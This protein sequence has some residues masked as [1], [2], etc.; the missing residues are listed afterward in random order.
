MEVKHI[1]LTDI[2][3]DEAFNCRG[4]ISPMDVVDLSKD[5]EER[6]LIQPV[7]VRPY[8][9]EEET[10]IG[11]KYLLIV[12]YRRYTAHKILGRETI[13]CVIRTNIGD[14]TSTRLFNLSE[15]LHRK[16]LN[17]LQEAKALEKLMEL[18]LGEY[19]TAERLKKSRGWVQIRYMVLKLPVEVQEEIAAGFFTQPQIRDLYTHFKR[20]GKEACFDIAREFKDDK[21]KGRK[22]IRRKVDKDQAKSKRHRSRVDLFEM[23]DKIRDEFGNSIVTRTLA[24]CA[25]EITTAEF[26]ASLSNWTNRK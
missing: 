16:A 4:A 17:V 21:I 10:R 1:P 22:G 20:A 12:G 14:E 7:V 26:E 15:N 9:D 2:H 8:S 5:I 3:Y 23:Q 25:G 24:W 19:D 11:F 13:A 18:G 6:G